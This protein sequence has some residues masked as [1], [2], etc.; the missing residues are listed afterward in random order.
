MMTDFF[1][2]SLEDTEMQFLNKTGE[3][4]KKIQE[5]WK[6]SRYP[7]RIY[8][9]SFTLLFFMM[10]A[11]IWVGF[12]VLDKSFIFSGRM[13]DGLTQ[14]YVSL[15]YYGKYLREILTNL[16]VKHTL[17]VPMWDIHIGYGSDIL[18][19]LHYYTIGDP[20]SLLSVLVPVKY[21]EYLYDFLIVVRMYL[22]GVTFSLYC[23][24]HKNGRFPTLLGALLYTFA[25]WMMVTGFRHPFFINPCIYYPL[26]IMGIDKVFKKEKPYL[27]I[28]TIA[29][30]AMSSFYYFYMLGIF[31]VIYAVYRYFMIFGKIR[32][33][34][35]FGWIGR[36]AVYCVIG[37]L[38]SA[39]IFLPSVMALFGTDRVNADN[40]IQDAYKTKYYHMLIPA[41]IGKFPAHYTVIG[42]SAV[43]AL[44][45]FL[46]FTA[47]KR[48]RE[49]KLGF[50]MCIVFLLFPF[51]AHVFNGFSY[52]TNRW[53]WVMVMLVCYIFV[54]MYPE[55]FGLSRRR[56]IVILVS[57]IL[58]AVYI[59][60]DTYADHKWNIASV[61]ILLGI[62]AVLFVG[63]GYFIRH[64][65]AAGLVLLAGIM[66]GTYLNIYFCFTDSGNSDSG[67]WKFADA[68]TA[69]E[70]NTGPVTE[71]LS[72]LPDI[73]DYR[74]EQGGAGITQN[75]TMLTGLN[76][77][78][79][80]FSLANGNVS[81]F[82]DEMY[83]NKSLEQNYQDLNGRTFLMKLLSMKYFVGSEQYVPFGYEKIDEVEVD[84][85]EYIAGQENEDGELDEA[86]QGNN[87]KRLVGIYEDTEALPLAYTYDSYIPREDYEEMSVMEKQQ[88]M[89]Q[90]VVLE[91]S[92]LSV[93][94][95]EDTSVEVPYT[96]TDLEDCELFENRIKAKKEGGSCVLE[97][98][99]VSES[100][101]Y[102][103]F[104][105]LQYLEVNRR[106]KYSDEEWK[107]LPFQTR[108]S[109][110]IKDEKIETDIDIDMQISIGEVEI[111]RTL[112]MSTDKNNF[113]NGRHNFMNHMG[114]YD[115]PV[116]RVKLTFNQKGSYRY[117]DLSVY[118][119]PLD[120]LGEYTVQRQ[121][122]EVKAL[123][124]GT[125]SVS[126]SV[127]LEEPKAVVFSLPYSD[128]WKV[129]VDGE[130]AELK[131]A[132]TM[133]MAVELSKGTHK[134]E[135]IYETPYLRLGM[136]LSLGG[137]LV[138]I[139]LLFVNGKKKEKQ[140]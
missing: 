23:F 10:F 118:F 17:E 2:L 20:L 9:I 27:L 64:R 43:G 8:W 121:T 108:R 12:A 82:F 16:F 79:F 1:H 45:L 63:Y 44:G 100:E 46:L 86:L 53:V 60:A 138:F 5:M 111:K 81:K 114:Y 52:A 128:G 58:F 21:T 68:G 126:A 116:T 139:G 7:K 131:K 109:I 125:N 99:G 78:Q 104:D 74:Y 70:K 50:L 94:K 31:M 124:T 93:C 71:A 73:L 67:V 106:H 65:A 18:T 24:Y 75:S 129:Q 110:R 59:C 96:I 87:T 120:K 115:T 28:L 34:E 29:V 84:G 76:G 3:A 47:R 107:S 30:S 127:T 132:N 11:A 101:L 95:V 90:G 85:D 54:K 123:Q 19:T 33:G 102:I 91:E 92:S 62:T 133:F 72:E 38:I 41:L 105:N 134:V 6:N 122:D 117:D 89:L 136:Y 42:I 4:E 48:N 39:I 83:S 36:F 61:C 97:F 119:Q 35:L 40:Y 69:Y 15:A 140:V 26:L 135:L 112:Q 130:D 37:V 14:H 55:L 57:I 51:A 66:A 22:A 77:G 88:A 49:L 13:A 25:Q 32:F 80:F 137:I 113:Y 56:R 98:Q 103:A